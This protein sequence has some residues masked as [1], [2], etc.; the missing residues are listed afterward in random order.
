V[1]FQDGN[2]ESC[3]GSGDG[4]KNFQGYGD[5]LS[6]NVHEKL[7]H[8]LV[9]NLLA[10][11]LVDPEPTRF[12]D[13][14]LNRYVRVQRVEDGRD[15]CGDERDGQTGTRWSGEEV[16]EGIPHHEAREDSAGADLGGIVVVDWSG[17]GE[18]LEGEGVL[19]DGLEVASERRKEG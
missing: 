7:V 14:V 10:S 5:G 11:F 18:E 8:L 3:V 4:S 9:V 17:Q 13:I 2:V 1:G 16:R 19:V 15:C 12:T 6:C